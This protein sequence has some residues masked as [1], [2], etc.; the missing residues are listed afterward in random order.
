MPDHLP[1]K[2]LITGGHE[3]GGVASFAE[4]LQRGFSEHGI[5]SEIIS[6][7]RILGH[8]RELRDPGI[9]KILS[10]TALFAAPLARR[11]ICMAHGVSRADYTGFRKAAGIIASFKVANRSSGAQLVS[12]SYYTAATLRAVFSIRTDAVIHN[13]L[14]ALFLEPYRYDPS[15]RCWL[16]YAGRLI[17][18]KNVHRMIPA[19]KDLLDEMPSLRVCIIGEGE[20]RPELER[21]VAGDSRFEFKG[22][23][24]D[25]TLR[26]YLRRT[27]VFVSG[28][29]AEGFGITYLEAMTQG[30]VVAMPAGGGGIE[31]SPERIGRG[32]QLLPP[33]WDRAELVAAFRSAFVQDWSPMDAKRFSVAAVAGSYLDV[34]SRFSPQG[35]FRAHANGRAR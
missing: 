35:L 6:P 16:T 24:D 20:L 32:V 4:A 33:S 31:I 13:P 22:S 34:D 11:A 7:A 1:S 14:K 29:E 2:V 10:T 30:C 19:M 15:G 28:N 26:D 27:R 8:M 5:E 12:V 25:P 21:M 23:P 3:L 9:L 18:V 17:A